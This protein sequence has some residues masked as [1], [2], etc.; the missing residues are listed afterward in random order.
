MI[1]NYSLKF[2]IFAIPSSPALLPSGEGSMK[3]CLSEVIRRPLGERDL[4]IE[5]F[6]NELFGIISNFF[7]PIWHIEMRDLSIYQ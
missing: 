6:S 2:D 5:G 3:T 1:P 4:G 7:C